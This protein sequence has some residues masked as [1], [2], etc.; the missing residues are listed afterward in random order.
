MKTSPI[1]QHLFRS[2]HSERQLLINSSHYKVYNR[3]TYNCCYFQDETY[4][5]A[6]KPWTIYRS[7]KNGHEYIRL[8]S[9]HN[10]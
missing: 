5:Y 7:E 6:Y 10:I 4:L 9:Y 3:S 1:V 2:K 8:H